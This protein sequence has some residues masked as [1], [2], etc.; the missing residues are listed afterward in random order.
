MNKVT[1]FETWDVRCKTIAQEVSFERHAQLE[2]W[3]AQHHDLP[4]WLVILAEEVGELSQAIL[5]HK[6]S[7]TATYLSKVEKEAVQCAAVASAIVQYCK[8]GEA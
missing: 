5:N 8:H 2:K 4:T 6:H 1:N 3:G 7:L